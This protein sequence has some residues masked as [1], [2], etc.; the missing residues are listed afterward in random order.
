M[1]S[2]GDRSAVPAIRQDAGGNGMTIEG[3][4]ARQAPGMDP[5][6][7]RQLG[8]D[9]IGEC[10]AALMVRFR[11]LDAAL[12]RMPLATDRGGAEVYCLMTDGRRIVFG[13]MAAAVRFRREPD[14]LVRD[15]LHLVLHCI[16]RHPF[17]DREENGEIFSVACDIMVEAL[18]ME[19]CGQQFSSKLDAARRQAVSALKKACPLFTPARLYRYI[20]DNVD[21]ARL[22]ELE[23]LFARDGHLMWACMQQGESRPDEESPHMGGDGAGGETGGSDG[24]RDSDGEQDADAGGGQGQE[25]DDADGDASQEAGQPGAPDESDVREAVQ[26]DD[27]AEAAWEQIA[28]QI[29]VDLETS[30]DTWGSQS[31]SLEQ[32]LALANREKYDYADFLRRFATLG[33]DMR[34][35]DDEFDYIYYT[36]GIDRYGNIP[37]VEPLEYKETDRVREFAIAVDTSGSCSGEL[38]RTFIQ[39]TYDILRQTESFGDEVNIHI[40]QCDAKIKDDTRITTLRELDAYLDGFTVRGFGGT[41]FRPVFSYIDELVEQGEFENLRGLIY[42]TDGLGTYPAHRPE[43]DTAFVFVNDGVSNV[44]VPPWAM[45]VILDEEGVKGI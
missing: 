35:N 42:F 38:V 34:V 5:E 36:Y 23:M 26:D 25:P 27:G 18:A 8:I 44:R 30:L 37:L 21:D 17:D 16:F 20:Y 22:R 2:L 15:L 10:R 1:E 7:L 43:Y 24:E 33:E 9:V 31:G 29:E 14:E 19:M 12:W 40:I 39:R 3:Y 11:Y 41:D 45:K 32:M 28:K 4:L 13:P 6:E